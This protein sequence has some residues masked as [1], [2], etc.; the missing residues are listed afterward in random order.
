MLAVAGCGPSGGGAPPAQCPSQRSASQQALQQRSRTAPQSSV[1]R[2]PQGR[3]AAL[4]PPATEPTQPHEDDKSDAAALRTSGPG[5]D[6]FDGAHSRWLSET[7]HHIDVTLDRGH[8]TLVVRREVYN[9][10]NLHEQGSWNVFVP[11]GAVAT[12]LRTL[13]RVDGDPVWHE[14]ELFEA[15]LARKRFAKL[16]GTASEPKAQALLY[17]MGRERLGLS[18]FPVMP[19][20][21]FTVEY[22]LQ[23]PTQYRGGAHE[24]ELPTLG[25]K[26]LPAV[27][28][29]SPKWPR[30]ALL[31][32][33]K[34]VGPGFTFAS[35]TDATVVVGLVPSGHEPSRAAT[36]DGRYASKFIEPGKTLTHV[37][38]GAAPQLS[39]LPEQAHVVLLLDASRS[40]GVSAAQAARTAAL[41]YLEALPQDAWV[42]VLSFDRSVH[43]HHGRFAP[44][45]LAI[46]ALKKHQITLRNGS[47][48]DDALEVAKRMLVGASA[49]AEKRVVVFSDTLTRSSLS[50]AQLALRFRSTGALVHGVEIQ[51]MTGGRTYMDRRSSESWD[52]MLEK[53]GG[54]FW[55]AAAPVEL[56]TDEQ[57]VAAHAA[58]FLEL[59]RPTR[60]HELSV[61]GKSISESV[62]ASQ[63]ADDLPE[64]EGMSYL[65]LAEPLDAVIV[66]RG[67]LWSR[68]VEK[69]LRADRD[70]NRLWSALVFGTSHTDEL[71]AEQRVELAEFGRVVS[72]ST[73]YL[74]SEPGIRPPLPTQ[75]R[76]DLDSGIGIG[77][78]GAHRT[79]APRVRTAAPPVSKFAELVTAWV[80][81]GGTTGTASISIETTRAEIVDV[82]GLTSTDQATL[83]DELREC[84]VESAWAFEL[85]DAFRLSERHTYTVAL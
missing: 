69:R 40:V 71:S 56:P 47:Q 51:A 63:V 34:P 64:G 42:E 15:A 12:G 16:D 45:Q 61:G 13:R 10:T 9:P 52:A 53:T 2:A 78:L 48:L 43:A 59:V 54:V 72:P 32:D 31:L 58:T 33:G 44:R 22:T 37:W 17:W 80:N 39:P 66:V 49:G 82:F 6:V 19:E 60:I 20:R 65:S 50:E 7:Q 26:A 77:R 21:S 14:A 70:Q 41:A 23:L 68:Q 67:K 76:S 4:E 84:I 11:S 62:F 25:Q 55:R 36:L 75:G 18:V 8:A 85:D 1:A 73:S 30:D 57:D 79:R 5:R 38:F 3:E 24:F 81:C 28:R 46:D 83:S 74:I 35:Q 27:V 29:L